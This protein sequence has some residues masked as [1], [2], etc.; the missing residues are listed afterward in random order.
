VPN[1]ALKN[2][3]HDKLRSVMTIAGVAFAVTLVFVQVGL[4]MGILDNASITIDHLQADLWV[5]SRNTPN[6]DFAH[7]FPETLVQRVRSAPGVERADNL[8]IQFLNLTL[9]SGAEEGMLVYGLEDFTRWGM[10][11]K[12]DSGD[13]ED[14]RR[15]AYM[16]L[17]ASAERRFGP[18]E[19]GDYREVMGRRV[20]IIGK[21]REALSFTTSPIAFLTY[22]LVQELAGARMDG[23]TTYILVRLAPGAD[24][25]AVAAEL[26]RRLP[27]ND[28]Y[29]REAWAQRSRSY[30]VASTGIGL[31]MYLT[32][33]LGCLVGVVVVTQTLYTSTMEH[34]KEFGTVK[35]IGG[36]NAD[37]YR[38]L[39]A[40]AVIAAVIGFLAG[41]LMA[42]ALAPAM[43]KI[44]LK[45]I[46]SNE[47]AAVVFVGTLVLC[48]VAALVSFRKVAKIDPALVFRG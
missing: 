9:P 15:G 12:I 5:T 40:Q 39:G 17:D 33:F 6:V 24:A 22:D 41:R 16:F 37:I 42:F 18:F 23:R 8:L 2:L 35:A 31:N 4:F 44:R 3:L 20:K 29:T 45:L 48:L 36:S 28:V 1:L 27:H 34:I 11:W 21:S 46:I 10:P 7:G 38:I 30:W 32:V 19:V 13:L 26:R 43:A 47:F 14:L 25:T